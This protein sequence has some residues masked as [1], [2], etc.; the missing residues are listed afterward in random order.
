MLVLDVQAGGLLVPGGEA[1]EDVE[2]VGQ[3]QAGSAGHTAGHTTA[4]AGRAET[5]PGVT[6][7]TTMGMIGRDGGRGFYLKEFYKQ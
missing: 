4:C 6:T 1:G 3:V 2:D 5:S 7:V